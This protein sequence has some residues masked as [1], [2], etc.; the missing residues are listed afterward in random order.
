MGMV[1]NRC[2]VA[3]NMAFVMVGTMLMIAGSPT[4]F[5]PKAPWA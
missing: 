3:W 5:A 2:P 1:L 4:P